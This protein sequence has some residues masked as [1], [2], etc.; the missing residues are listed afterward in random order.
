MTTSTNYSQMI[1]LHIIYVYHEGENVCSSLTLG[2]YKVCG[3]S[4]IA[5]Y[6]GD[7]L[8]CL[9]KGSRGPK[10]CVKCGIGVKSKIGLCMDCGHD[11]RA[12]YIAY[13]EKQ[14][15]LAAT[16]FEFSHLAAIEV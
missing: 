6:C 1:Y 16:H 9:R 4:C 7:H 10:A 13:M 2:F 3:R 5:K 15:R 11:R 12:H 14:N 8:I